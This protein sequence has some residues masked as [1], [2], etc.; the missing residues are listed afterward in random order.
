MRQVWTVWIIFCLLAS[1][2]CKVCKLHKNVLE[3]AEAS[4]RVKCV[5]MNINQDGQ[6]LL[7]NPG[8]VCIFTCRYNSFRFKHRCNRNGQWDS[9][10]KVTNCDTIQPIQPSCPDPSTKW[11][12]WLWNCSDG[13]AKCIGSCNFSRI[14]PIELTCTDGR[15]L[16]NDETI[17]LDQDCQPPCTECHSPPQPTQP[18]IGYVFDPDVAH[19]ELACM[20]RPEKVCLLNCEYGFVA[21]QTEIIPCDNAPKIQVNLTCQEPVTVLIGGYAPTLKTAMTSVEVYHPRHDTSLNIP[22]IPFHY[23]HMVGLWYD[24]KL[25]VCG[26][27]QMTICYELVRSNGVL[28][29]IP[30]AQ[31]SY[32]IRSAVVSVTRPKTEWSLYVTGHFGVLAYDYISTVIENT[33]AFHPPLHDDQHC[34]FSTESNII[35]IG[36]H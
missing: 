4:S 8:T 23:E 21:S 28:E 7:F 11:T 29:W 10:P 36:K 27:S 24:G 2:T 9:Q 25:I 6:D 16:I 14:M 31:H 13:F 34:T 1:V 20:Y 32:Y 3:E 19:A 12:N 30:N 26:E 33:E 5:P 22:D 35:T 18:C 17:D 15:W